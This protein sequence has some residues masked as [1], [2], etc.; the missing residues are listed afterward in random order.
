MMKVLSETQKAK[1]QQISPGRLSLC[2]I[3]AAS[4]ESLAST[5][6]YPDEVKALIGL[7]WAHVSYE[8]LKDNPP[9]LR[10]GLLEQQDWFITLLPWVFLYKNQTL[11]EKWTK[12]I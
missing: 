5:E 11:T 10:V 12:T 8:N 2:L 3:P 6:K 9:S 7:D 1:L 4:L